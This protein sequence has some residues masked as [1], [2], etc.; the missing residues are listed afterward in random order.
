MPDD[1]LRDLA[2][3]DRP[4]P[5]TPDLRARLEAA[6]SA[7]VPPLPVEL[8]DDL[9]LLAL[10]DAGGERPLPE[11][12]RR[13]LE[14][15]LLRQRRRGAQRALA[16]AA[17][18][19]LVVGLGAAFLRDGPRPLGT[20]VAGP[21]RS[22]PTTALPGTASPAPPTL[23][24]ATPGPAVGVG[25]GT[26]TGTAGGSTG[27]APTTGG[28]GVGNGPPPPFA[29]SPDPPP[30]ASG[31]V[32]PGGT[33]APAP[34]PTRSPRPLAPLVIG[35]AGTPD[36][37]FRAYLQLLNDAGGINGRRVVV[38]S[39]GPIVTVNFGAAGSVAARPVLEPLL[40][41]SATLRGDAFSLSSP[42]ERQAH[43]A[44]DAV[45]PTAAPDRFAVIYTGT[46]VFADVVPDAYEEALRDKG[47]L[48]V[49]V[50][51]RPGDDPL[52]PP[53][54]EAAFLSL[55]T[56]AARDWSRANGDTEFA[57]G[58]AG[59]ASLHDR[60]IL[61]DL[62]LGT[63][64]VSPYVMPDVFET[65]EMRRRVGA[66]L[67]AATVHGWVTAKSLAVALWRSAADTPAEV[68]AALRSMHGFDSH[69]AP[70]YRVRA[71]TNARVPEAI[72]LEVVEGRAFAPR[73]EFR[74]DPR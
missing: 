33:A 22:A 16:V 34:S 48:A 30:A 71:G 6:L 41:L 11:P 24:P 13:R 15:A 62:P 66:P 23:A 50:A 60:A 20:P 8:R 68:T 55:D 36:A 38:G 47:V 4:R 44:V 69:Y 32:V 45:F 73:G 27:G 26:T 40:S 10:R 3:A 35:V 65:Q 39:R 43:I 7:D 49:R 19:V 31:T 51:Y 67:S 64:V 21:S 12:A 2:G 61:A 56:A 29:Y 37:G 17:A 46:G 57:R 25:T 14:T 74:T 1:P 63:R 42:V 72:V 59:I 18:A 58:V 5:L 52:V 54:A 53:G 70:P 28:A 9:M